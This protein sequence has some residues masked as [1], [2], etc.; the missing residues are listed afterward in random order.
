MLTTGPSL[1]TDIANQIPGGILPTDKRRDEGEAWCC[2]RC[3]RMLSNHEAP[4]M[5]WPSDKGHWVLT[6]CHRCTGKQAVFPAATSSVRSEA[7]GRPVTG[8]EAAPAPLTNGSG[9]IGS[10]RP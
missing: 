10:W 2:S 4:L 7:S 5:I 6:Y 3:D 9:A 8:P 1:M